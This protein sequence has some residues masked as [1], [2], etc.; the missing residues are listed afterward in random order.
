MGT[1][2]ANI[3]CQ[4]W[5]DGLNMS[6]WQWFYIDQAQCVNMMFIEYG[7]QVQINCHICWVNLYLNLEGEH[8][9]YEKNVTFPY[10]KVVGCPM[11]VKWW[12]CILYVVNNVVFFKLSKSCTLWNSEILFVI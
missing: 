6:T 7:Y 12:L 4:N 2:V 11:Y 1:Y 3:V 10:K 9:K 8:N 5:K